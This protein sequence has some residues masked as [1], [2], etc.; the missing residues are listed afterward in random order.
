MVNLYFSELQPIRS[1]ASTTPP[2]KTPIII[3]T[4]VVFIISVALVIVIYCCWKRM[5]RSED[6]TNTTSSSDGDKE[7]MLASRYQEPDHHELNAR[8][9]TNNDSEQQKQPSAFKSNEC[10]Y[11]DPSSPTTTKNPNEANELYEPVNDHKPLLGNYNNNPSLKPQQCYQDVQVRKPVQLPG[12]NAAGG[13]DYND[14][15][16]REVYEPIGSPINKNSSTASSSIYKS[17]SNAS[18]GEPIYKSPSDASSHG[19]HIY[20]SPSNAAAHS[21]KATGTNEPIYKK[22]SNAT[23]VGPIYKTPSNASSNRDTIC[24]SPSNASSQN[25]G[26]TKTLPIYKSPS[27]ASDGPT[28]PA[29]AGG[30]VV[31]NKSGYQVPKKKYQDVHSRAVITDNNNTSP[32]SGNKHTDSKITGQQSDDGDSPVYTNVKNEDKTIYKTPSNIP[33]YQTPRNLGIGNGGGDGE[34]DDEHDYELPPSSSTNTITTNNNTNGSIGG[35][36]NQIY[37]N[38]KEIH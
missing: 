25:N 33:K 23:D 27:N 14:Y 11:Y 15:D 1:D 20:K 30:G 38:V 19:T 2:S 22:P 10:T 13:V 31:S 37:Q 3:G 16:D 36:S 26:A 34:E 17:P 21:A 6:M 29:V 35:D 7:G 8:L 18:C 24:K 9:L 12:L 4:V 32:M 28:R 5:R